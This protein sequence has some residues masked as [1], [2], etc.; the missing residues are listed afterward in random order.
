[1][2]AQLLGPTPLN[3]VVATNVTATNVNAASVTTSGAISAQRLSADQQISLSSTGTVKAVE[4]SSA[5]GYTLSLV[6]SAGAGATVPVLS[7][8]SAGGAPSTAA[9]GAYSVPVSH[10]SVLQS[11]DATIPL[12]AATIAVAI[13]AITATSVV[14]FSPLAPPDATCV[15]LHIVLAAGVGFSITGAANA[16]AAVPL[17]YFVAKY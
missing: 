10:A 8:S 1:M 4:S 17:S 14:L 9:T 7:V 15:G 3:T 2:S 13:P 12:G 11:G 16:T 6:D 5:S